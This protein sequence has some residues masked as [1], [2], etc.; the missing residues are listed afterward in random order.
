MSLMREINLNKAY[1]LLYPRQTVLIVSISKEGK[2]NI[3]TL[4]WSSPVSFNPPM[5]CIAVGKQRYSVEL[6]KETKEFVVAIPSEGMEKEVL[7]C[8]SSSGR[9]IDKFKETKL[10]PIKA[11]YV[12]PPLIKECVANLECE[13]VEEIETGDHILF[14]ARILAAYER[15]GKVLMDL[16]GRKFIGIKKSSF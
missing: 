4:N 5:L 10:T 8:G 14:I 1:T 7:F 13:V 3:M 16:G 12:R 9:N 11:K 6:I 2:P 15:E